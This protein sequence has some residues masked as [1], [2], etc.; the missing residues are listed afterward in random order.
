MAM[1]EIKIDLVPQFVRPSFRT[2]RPCL[3]LEDWGRIGDDL[4]RQFPMIRFMRRLSDAEWRGEE[5]P[6]L[7]IESDLRSVLPPKSYEFYAF[8]EPDLQLNLRREV[9]KPYTG[10]S[11]NDTVWRFNTWGL[12]R[13]S[14][15][16]GVGPNRG[17]DGKGP[18][19]INPGQIDFAG[20]PGN[21]NHQ[22]LAQQIFGI[23]R[24]HI[25]KEPLR[26]VK[27]PS[28]ETVL[29]R[30][31]GLDWVGKDALRWARED[32]KRLLMPDLK[33]DGTGRVYRPVDDGSQGQSREG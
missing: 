28:G 29:H 8:F 15:T 12:P 24:R 23:V 19:Q 9:P 6:D 3:T 22:A 25:T 1:K 18:E 17:W 21:K 13:L 5:L 33:P 11:G 31:G 14:V 16:P 4:V 30:K 26:V 10:Y 27:Y 2:K 7:R 32:P 20:E